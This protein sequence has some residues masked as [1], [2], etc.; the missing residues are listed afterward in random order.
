M[1]PYQRSKLKQTAAA[2]SRVPSWN[3][4]PLRRTN[5]QTRPSALTFQLVAR[6]GT[7]RVP[8]G[9]SST[10]PSRIWSEIRTDDSSDARAASREIASAPVPQTRV[11]PAGGG[12]RSGPSARGRDRQREDAAEEQRGGERRF[13][14]PA[15]STHRHPDEAVAGRDPTWLRAD[16]DA[17]DLRFV[18]RVD[19]D[20]RARGRVRDPDRPGL[21]ATSAGRPP[22]RSVASTEFVF[23]S[24]R[25][26]VPVPIAFTGQHWNAGCVTSQ[27]EPS[28]TASPVGTPTSRGMVAETAFG[29]RVESN[30]SELA[31]GPHRSLADRDSRAAS[32]DPRVPRPGQPRDVERRPTRF[33]TASILAT[34]TPGSEMTSQ[35]SPSPPARLL[36]PAP[37]PKGPEP[38]GILLT[39]SY[40]LGS[41]RATWP[42]TTPCTG[43]MWPETSSH[44][45]VRADHDVDRR[46]SDGD[47]PEDRLL[48]SDRYA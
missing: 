10:R 16:L 40:T 9:A 39:T 27:T 22:N 32:A 4:T 46:S 33:V 31:G 43:S 20:D 23:G 21:T 5:V 36:P 45:G 15:T 1:K 17:L 6:P 14:R 37:K 30:H 7:T 18:F 29:A 35:T 25:V 26:S 11:P 3:L 24:I 13:G 42:R 44:D 2:S 47:R 12:R 48:P 19:A 34:V 28:P 41:M 8:P 38:S